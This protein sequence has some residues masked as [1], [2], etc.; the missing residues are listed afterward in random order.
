MGMSSFFIQLR[1]A[2]SSPQP[3]LPR[4]TDLP[5]SAYCFQER[6]CSRALPGKT[7]SEHNPISMQKTKQ[8]KS[9]KRL[10]SRRIA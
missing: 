5:D 7:T 4:L 6:S 3:P 10:D 1:P 2:S 9:T 8:K